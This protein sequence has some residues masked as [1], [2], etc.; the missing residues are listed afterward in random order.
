MFIYQR[1]VILISLFFS[2]SVSAKNNVITAFFE[3]NSF[4]DVLPIQQLINDEWKDQPDAGAN[5]GFSQNEAGVAYQWNNITFKY[6]HRFD[7]FV[8]ANNDTLNLIYLDKN[9]LSYS[10]KGDVDVQLEST[11]FRSEGVTI[12]YSNR[13]DNFTAGV[14]F[15][16]WD[17]DD[18]RYSFVQ[19]I[20][21]QSDTLNSDSNLSFKEFY[22]TRN[23]LKRP[24]SGEWNKEGHGI[25]M[26]IALDWANDFLSIHFIGKDYFNEYEIDSVG[27][28]EGDF[29]SNGSFIDDNGFRSFVPVFRGK[30][31]SKDHKFSI[32]KR[33]NLAATYRYKELDYSIKYLRQYHTDFYYLGLGNIDE[34][35]SYLFYVNLKD[36]TPGFSYQ[37]KFLSLNLGIDD[38]DINKT[39][40]VRIDTAINVTF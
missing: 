39:Y 21:Y 1:H 20:G 23:F 33:T 10:G 2:S 11:K 31:S 6:S 3:S 37:N 5:K 22:S 7:F 19:G 8:K 24:D 12:G 17:I 30:E 18:F 35:S 4:S 26:N 9:D 34:T 27:Y 32:A 38:I 13:F 25:S 16:Y 29:D 15:S 40:Q 14:E 36:F 28:S